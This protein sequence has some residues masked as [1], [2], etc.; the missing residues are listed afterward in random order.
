MLRMS[1]ATPKPL[2][3]FASA[4]LPQLWKAL[5]RLGWNQADLARGI[6]TTPATASRILYGKRGVG[7]ELARRID[8]L[9]GLKLGVLWDKPL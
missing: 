7:R 8:D 5:A 6:E 2:G 3:P 1:P 9:L 4:A